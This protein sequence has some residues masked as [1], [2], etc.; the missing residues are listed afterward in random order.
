ML[1]PSG[2]LLQGGKYRI[3]RHIASG[4]FGNTYEAVDTSMGNI[5][6][7]IKEFFV[8]DFCSRANNMVVI[9]NSPEKQ[10]LVRKLKKKFLDEA[11]AIFRMRH[12]NIV[13]VYS[14]FEENDT[15]YYV[16]EYVDGESLTDILNKKNVLLEDEA[17]HYIR[18]I[19]SALSHVHSNKCCHLDV[20]P[21]NIIIGSEGKA[22]LIDFGASKYY[23]EDKDYTTTTLP[24]LYTPG[25]APYEQTV[26]GITEFTPASD[27]YSL[28][29]TLYRML[30]GD[31]PPAS[32][33]LLAGDI[34][35]PPLPNGISEFT[36]K[37]VEKAMEP[38]KKN[39]TQSIE[40]FLSDLGD[41]TFDS[42]NDTIYQKGTVT[43]SSNDS[44]KDQDATK[45]DLFS[46]ILSPQEKIQRY[47]KEFSPL[48]TKGQPIRNA[49]DF[50][51]V[52]RAIT[53]YE[54]FTKDIQVVLLGLYSDLKEKLREAKDYIETKENV[55]NF[56]KNHAYILNKSFES[57]SEADIPL[58]NLAVSEYEKSSRLVQNR[59]GNDTKKNLSDKLSK[60]EDI[61]RR[62]EDESAAINFRYLYRYSLNNHDASSEEELLNM[63]CD[64]AMLSERAKSYVGLNHDSIR[65]FQKKA[66]KH[67]QGRLKKNPYNC[68]EETIL[69]LFSA[70][71][72]KD[73]VAAFFRKVLN[74]LT[75]KELDDEVLFYFDEIY[76]A[77][78]NNEPEVKALNIEADL[79]INKYSYINTTLPNKLSKTEIDNAI[80]EIKQVL[81]RYPKVYGVGLKLSGFLKTV[82]YKRG[83]IE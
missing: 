12:D 40:A 41:E 83:L 59:L 23:N 13:R 55:E 33:L 73:N 80:N 7:A 74:G 79:L 35:L 39:R 71:I 38:R 34:V 4:G 60:A 63:F 1:L 68:V 56:R 49:E 54:S 61:V 31:T 15:A 82:R 24:G 64:Y 45:I 77:L 20:K 48:A 42:R 67:L 52:N 57:I 70:P 21:S 44:G 25:Y 66:I 14:R 76:C 10:D 43:D 11:L 19:A 53:I 3:I 72:T 18:Q 5:R 32:G 81:D 47:L 69:R 36:R 75:E 50:E 26:D 65:F 58:L 16:M 78:I 51:R 46:D 22:I 9:V 28:G 6:V 27:I 37:A 62:K 8:K 30:S 29:A 2:T 17:L